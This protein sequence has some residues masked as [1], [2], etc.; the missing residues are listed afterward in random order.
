M[1]TAPIA[2][3]D[4]ALLSGMFAAHAPALLA[5]PQRPPSAA[6]LEYAQLTRQL[7]KQ[8]WQ[9]LAPPALVAGPAPLTA[10]AE[11]VLVAELACRVVAGVF[12][13]CDAR[14]GRR[15]IV[16][17]ARSALL[18]LLQAK[19]WVLTRLVEQPQPLGSLLRINQLRRKTERWSD[20]LLGGLPES[21]SAAQ[22]AID[23]ERM[24]AFA[25]KSS[26]AASQA[27]WYL[28]LVSL[29]LAMPAS[30]IQDDPRRETHRELMRRL[31]SFWPQSAFDGEGLLR[32]PLWQRLR[33]VTDTSPHGELFAASAPPTD[34]YAVLSRRLR[35]R[36]TLP[37]HEDPR[38]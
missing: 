16:P 20:C 25:R 14:G 8:W 17:F 15:A 22:F 21:E 18:D 6:L 34:E 5:A 10:I 3:R 30:L 33:G 36:A 24:R 23:A 2:V 19:H 1:T 35:A 13:V 26:G 29:R 27:G 9:T 28:T 32:G 11:E 12:A 31:I 38:S 4:L 37:E 7:L